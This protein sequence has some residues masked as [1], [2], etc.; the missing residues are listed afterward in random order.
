M[1]NVLDQLGKKDLAL[2]LVSEFLL[3][4]WARTPE[5]EF[6]N[7]LEMYLGQCEAALPRYAQMSAEERHRITTSVKA[8]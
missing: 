3:G 8:D 2:R 4:M 1:S 7:L 5:G 6:R